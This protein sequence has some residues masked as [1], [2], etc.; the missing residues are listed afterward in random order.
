MAQINQ[1]DADFVRPAQLCRAL[2]PI[3]ATAIVI[4]NVIGTG[5]FKKPQSI[6]EN[7]PS[8]GY[9]ALV[10]ILGGVIALLGSFA[11]AEVSVLF[12]RSGG[13]YV[14][15]REGF[16]RVF[17]FLSG[18][19]DFGIIRSGSIAA[20]ATVVSESLHDVLRSVYAVG[21]RQNVIGYWEE[22]LLTVGFIAILAWVNIRGVKWGGFV[23]TFMTALKV[24]VLFGILI[25][26]LLLWR[27]IE[28][29]SPAETAA[30]VVAFSWVGL[31]TAMLGVQ[32]AYHGWMNIAQIAEEVRTPQ[33]NIPLSLLTGV[34]CITVLYLGANVAFN[35]VIPLDEMRE[36]KNT[37]VTAEFCLRLLGGIGAGL[38]ATAIMTSAFGTLSGNLLVGPRLLF[39]MGR[40]QLAPSFLAAVHPRFQTP[41]RAIVV[42]AVWSCFL[43]LGGAALSRFPLPVWNISEDY[44]LDLNLPP[45]KQLF[46]VLTDYAMLGALTFETLAVS[47]I[48]VFRWRMPNVERPY[49]CLGYPVTPAF[50]IL[51]LS[52]VAVNSLMTQRTESAVMVGFVAVGAVVYWLAMRQTESKSPDP[53]RLSG[54]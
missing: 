3:M 27:T 24:A 52:A 54:V 38:A 9:V 5:V 23:Q 40:D 8:F 11:I 48:F 25:L 44:Q 20:L 37:T 10:W 28:Q 15:L 18:W 32:W 2:G 39:A 45:G 6:A 21:S 29:N 16:G 53:N 31:G 26:P 50:Y 13:N 51:I 41:A 4:G 49:R 17:G 42:E 19:V 22:R 33:R 35:F 7:V 12:P 14:F 1:G 43:V 36:V 30:S 47:T 46:D 34:F